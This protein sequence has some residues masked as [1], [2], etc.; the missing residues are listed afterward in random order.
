[1]SEEKKMEILDF[2]AEWCGP[3]QMMKPIMEEFEGAHPEIKVTKV[4]IDEEEELAEK[5]EVSSIPCLVVVKNGEEVKR[6][7]GMQSAKKLEKLVGV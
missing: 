6:V 5:Y 4:N 2:W 7:V 1:M 3:C